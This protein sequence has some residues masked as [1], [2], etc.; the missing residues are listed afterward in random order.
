MAYARMLAGGYTHVVEFHYL[1]HD[2]SGKPYKQAAA[3][4]QIHVEAAEEVGIG[5]TLTPVF[6]KHGGFGKPAQ[7]RQRRFLFKDVS[8]YLRHLDLCRDIV[9]QSPNANLGCGVHSLRASSGE[10]TQRI[11]A[12]T[13]HDL[14]FHLHAAEQVKEVEECRAAT[15]QSPIAWILDH[16]QM[17]PRVNITHATHMTPEET[18]YLGLSGATVVLCPSTEGN[19]GDGVFPLG[20]YLTANGRFALGTDSHIG[21]SPFEDLRW[22]DYGQRLY[23][24]QRNVLA[25]IG[26]QR[27]ADC[28]YS[29]ALSGGWSAAGLKDSPWAMGKP[30]DAVILD[31]EHIA[32]VSKPDED[33]LSAAV[34]AGEQT[35][36]LGV[37]A[38]GRQLIKHQTHRS[39]QNLMASYRTAMRSIW[40]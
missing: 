26:G 39:H 21:M 29:N 8:E 31:P 4:A 37:I 10:E 30:F 22:L 13:P 25:T 17:G 32:L 27:S 16:L 23:R 40:K 19:L 6:Y 28:L 7:E 5:I 11:F 18:K 33:V 9:K 14:P 38:R 20:A 1:H 3:L 24:K 34:Y 35:M 15:G 36:I 2:E 12:E